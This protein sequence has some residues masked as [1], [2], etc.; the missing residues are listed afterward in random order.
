MAV[1]HLPHRRPIVGAVFC[2]VAA[3][4]FAAA[5]VGQPGSS[6][7]GGT[8]V[9]DTPVIPPSI[10]PATNYGTAWPELVL[11][12][13]GLVAFRKVGGAAGAQLVPDLADALP[14]PTNGGKTYAFRL[15]RGIRYSDG[16]ALRASDFNHAFERIFRL[17]GPT[18]RSLYGRIVGARRCLADPTACDLSRGVVAN[19]AAATVTFHLTRSDAEFLHKLALPFA[20]AVPASAP[21]ADI[22]PRPLPGTGAYTWLEHTPGRQ[23]TLVRNPYFVEWSAAAQPAGYVDRFVFR[24]AGLSIDAM[25]DEVATGRADYVMPP[26]PL[27]AR[28]VREISARYPSQTHVSPAAGIFYMALNTRVPPFN[29]VLVRRALNYATDRRRMVAI[30]GGRR[31]ARPACQMLPRAF[32]GHRPYCPYSKGGRRRTWKAPDMRRARRLIARSRTKGK[33]VTVVNPAIPPGR[34]TG[35]Y[36]VRLLRKLGYRARLRLLPLPVHDRFVKN[37]RNRVQ[38]NLQFWFADYPAASNFLHVLTSCAAFRRNSDLN[39]NVAGFCDRRISARMNRALALATTNPAAANRLWA[40]IDRQVTDRAPEV[41]LIN[42]SVV[43]FLSR[44]VGNFQFNPQWQFLL[45]QAW[46]Q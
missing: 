42:P 30:L 2:A 46:V 24:S 38:M 3:L 31:Q 29:N 16:S 5:S 15:R 43:T 37:S 14:R 25:I 19:D 26:G 20:F 18:A 36:F 23:T 22:G 1:S 28:R 4:L 35:R 41:V 8:M 12:H 11:T 32:P 9:I 10:D 40:R 17:R 21:N 34:A 6:H 39:T 27:P 44:R 7:R 33:R 45:G 13:D